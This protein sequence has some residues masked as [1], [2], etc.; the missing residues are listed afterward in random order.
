ME[1]S[2]FDTKL[3]RSRNTPIRFAFATLVGSSRFWFGYV[4]GLSAVA[5]LAASI[6]QIFLSIAAGVPFGI[7]LILI[8]LSHEFIYPK[9]VID[10]ENR[11]LTKSK[12][13]GGG[14]YSSIPVD[15]IE[16][17]SVIRMSGAA[18]VNFHYREIEF[19][20]PYATAIDATDVSDFKS[21]LGRLGIRV[22]VCEPIPN[23]VWSRVIATPLV[24]LGTIITLWQVFGP[25]AFLT[26][27]VI[28]PT[29]VLVGFVV[30]SFWQRHVRKFEQNDVGINNSS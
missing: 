28:V 16:H 8:W 26:D 22:N 18:L 15:D 9:L 11:T 21:Q 5:L 20:K 6:H 1:N 12:P 2:V 27:A 30:Y 17:V 29:I 14:T 10:A 4:I 3:V 23:S 13:Y 7:C 24:I 19:S 25:D